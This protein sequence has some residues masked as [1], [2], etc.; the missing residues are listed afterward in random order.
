ML[1]AAGVSPPLILLFSIFQLLKNTRTLLIKWETHPLFFERTRTEGA[2][3]SPGSGSTL[4]I[5]LPPHPHCPEMPPH[6]RS[7]RL[8]RARGHG[9][10]G[11][12]H[13]RP[14]GAQQ[15]RGKQALCGSRLQRRERLR[16]RGWTAPLSGGPAC[17]G[18]LRELILHLRN[19]QKGRSREFPRQTDRQ[20]A[21]SDS[22][23]H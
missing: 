20:T 7:A 10:R 9:G 11:V 18:A 3:A 15:G 8:D 13:L 17:P 23:R 22:S 14:Q 19:S 1:T 6:P 4:A 2:E 16:L 12:P 21:T 5:P